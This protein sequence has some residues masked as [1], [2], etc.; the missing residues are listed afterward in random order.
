MQGATPMVVIRVSRTGIGLGLTSL[1]A[2]VALTSDSLSLLADYWFNKPEYSHGPIIPLVAAFLIWQ[3]KDWLER[4][5][6]GAWAGVLGCSALSWR[7]PVGLSSPFQSL[8]RADCFVWNCAGRRTKVFRRLWAPLL[9]LLFMIPLPSSCSSTSP[10]S[11]SCCRRRS[12]S[13]S[14]ACSASASTSKATS[15]TSACT[16][17]RWP[18]PATGCATC[19][20]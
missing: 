5:F 3:Q 17:C 1:A 6:G 16:S 19:F 14:S 7:G 20:R 4:P 2:I 12:A 8:R 10:P 18:R 9:I 11:C 13:G 15:S